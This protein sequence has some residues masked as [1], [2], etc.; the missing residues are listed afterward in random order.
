MAYALPHAHHAG[1]VHR[2]LKPANILV[3]S[4]GIKVLDFG[5]AKHEEA[6]TSGVESTL[7]QTGMIPG[8]PH[9]MSPEQVEGKSDA[10]TG[11]W[12]F[13]YVLRVDFRHGLT[14]VRRVRKRNLTTC[15]S[16]AI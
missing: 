8:M 3:T 14:A 9:Y 10:R 13:E 15:C 2:D 7:T 16:G 12:A 4:A 6:N 5:L 11:I 1:I